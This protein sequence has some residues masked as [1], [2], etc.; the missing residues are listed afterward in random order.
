MGDYGLRWQEWSRRGELVMKERFF[1]T[2]A[3]RAKFCDKLAAK[4]NF[5]AFWGSCDPLVG[6]ASDGR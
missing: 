2:L 4:D 6:G 3:A 5:H 1:R